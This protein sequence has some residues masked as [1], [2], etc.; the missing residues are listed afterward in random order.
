MTN[1]GDLKAELLALVSAADDY[2][3]YSNEDDLCD[4]STDYMYLLQDIAHA[5]K[6]ANF[7]VKFNVDEAFNDEL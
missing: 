5:F 1:Y 6:K 2:Y 3:D 7:D 4:A